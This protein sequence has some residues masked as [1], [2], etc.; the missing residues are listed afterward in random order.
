MHRTTLSPDAQARARATIDVTAASDPDIPAIRNAWAALKDARGQRVL[1]ARLIPA[2]IITPAAQ[3]YPSAPPLARDLTAEEIRTR[4][5]QKA[6]AYIARQRAAAGG[7]D[8]A[9]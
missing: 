6:I 7:M 1:P 9:A 3:Q 8:G 2:H 5:R 4:A